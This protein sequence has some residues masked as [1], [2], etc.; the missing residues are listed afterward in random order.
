MLCCLSSKD[1]AVNVMSSSNA[2]VDA[3]W[4]DLQWGV[5]PL[6]EE[7]RGNGLRGEGPRQGG[8]QAQGVPL[9]GLP[10]L[11][12]TRHRQFG[13][14]M[15][16]GRCS[17]S[18]HKEITCDCPLNRWSC[19]GRRM[20]L[21]S[22]RCPSCQTHTTGRA[23]R[24]SG[25]NHG[26]GPCFK[27]V[28]SSASIAIAVCFRM[29]CNDFQNSIELRHAQ[30]APDHTSWIYRLR[31][32]NRDDFW[33]ECRKSPSAAPAGPLCIMFSAHSRGGALPSS[34]RHSRRGTAPGPFS[35]R[36]S[37]AAVRLSLNLAGPAEPGFKTHT[38]SLQWCP[39]TWLC[40]N[41]TMSGLCCAR[42]N[43]AAGLSASR[44]KTSVSA[45]RY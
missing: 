39:Y 40:P 21:R 2:R 26:Q 42:S 4:R 44:Y 24:P 45:S 12:S 22:P 31:L 27:A 8:H 37:S 30:T 16:H 7:E 17:S 41:T 15:A 29:L 18:S 36:C 28:G 1:G 35:G 14:V 9:D 25:A 20:T 5:Q 6:L 23:S 19:V 43:L 33:S 38:P 10:Q 13:I 11:I 3:D 32:P 34:S